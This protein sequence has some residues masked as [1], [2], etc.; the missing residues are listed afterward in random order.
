MSDEIFPGQ[1]ERTL[2]WLREQGR[3]PTPWVVI[4]EASDWAEAVRFAEQAV[5][6]QDC[7]RLIP[8]D[9]SIDKH[10]DTGNN[11]WHIS[12]AADCADIRPEE[13]PVRPPKILVVGPDGSPGPA[14]SIAGFV[15][16]ARSLTTEA[17]RSGASRN[18][19]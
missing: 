6:S 7:N 18:I 10:S 9:Y 11:A 2:A 3:V 8:Y 1:R 12:V 16:V 15:Y 4:V 19:R 13:Y 14:R 5:M 17:Q